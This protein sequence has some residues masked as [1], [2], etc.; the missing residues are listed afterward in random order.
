MTGQSPVLAI[1]VPDLYHVSVTF[2]HE[3]IKA[4]APGR[5]VVVHLSTTRSNA[6]TTVPALE[7]VK[8]RPWPVPF[9]PVLSTAVRQ[10]NEFR[11]NRLDKRQAATVRQFLR[12][13]AVT[14]LF[15][16]FATSGVVIAPLARELGLPLKA[17][18][19]GWDINVI[20]QM[21]HWRARYAG[22]F[23]S[24][25]KLAAVVP[26][27]HDRMA[28]I[29]A[30]REKIAIV[31]CAVNAE[32]FLVVDQLSVAPPRVVMVS[33][34]TPQKGPLASLAAFCQAATK[35]DDLTLSTSW[36]VSL[37]EGMGTAPC[38]S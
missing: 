35:R 7:V 15:A 28:E 17:M 9:L 6:K 29:R 25:V 14:H 22:L 12:D 5:T 37:L 13:H 23:R 4:I 24:D 18:S 32:P 20:G 33:R 36:G 16:E 21:P 31:P 10:V 34:L 8:A 11:Q 38:R 1:V 26:F 19:H 3:H 27:L 2:F 30:P